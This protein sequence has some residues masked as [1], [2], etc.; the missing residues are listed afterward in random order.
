MPGLKA[1][2]A[3]RTI[4]R[5]KALGH[6]VT[7]IT[8]LLAGPALHA[9]SLTEYRV[10]G[11]NY[12]RLVDWARLHGLRYSRTTG[13]REAHARD[14]DTHVAVQIDA[15]RIEFNEIAVWLSSP[16]LLADGQVVVSSLDVRGVLDPLLHPR[17]AIPGRR[18]KTVCLD[19]GHGGKAPGQKSGS[20]L[21]K[22]YTLALAEEV[23]SRLIKAGFNVVMTRRSDEFVDLPER[24]AIASRFQ[25]DLFVSLHY[26]A[27]PDG[28]SEAGGVEVYAMTPA[29][30]RSTN[31]SNDIGPL[32]AWAG[33]EFDADNV[34][35]AYQ[36]QRSLV[37]RLSGTQDR[38]VRRARFIVLRLAEMPAV[39]IEAGFMSNP[40]DARW[41]Y[42]DTGRKRTA[43]AI[44]D[45]ISAYKRAVERPPTPNP[46]SPQRT[47]SSNSS[48]SSDVPDSARN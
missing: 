16:V 20:R 46:P 47:T 13:S 12:I 48:S 22:T 34:Q 9:A 36:L 8:W 11:Q 23:R 10:G 29:G 38:G 32:H 24:N 26:N 42:S 40:G 43:Q 14:N 25:A 44:A 7:L 3:A 21:E 33:N 5:L 18:I 45:G 4:T 15:S 1:K 39:L 31:I 2:S 37:Q 30:T 27:S 19:P 35:L 41:I 17:K 28:G 6:V